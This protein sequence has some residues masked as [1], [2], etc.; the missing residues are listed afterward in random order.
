MARL[1]RSA[2]LLVLFGTL[3]L[4]A[5]AEPITAIISAIGSAIGA[6]GVGTLVSWAVVAYSVVSSIYGSVQ[7]KKQAR[8]AAERKFQ[9]DVANLQDRTTTI[10]ASDDSWPVVYGQP[11]P[12]GGSVKAVITSG[13]KAQYKHIVLVLA[14]HECEAIDDVL[15]DGESLQLNGYGSSQHPAYQLEYGLPRD[16]TY[17]FEVKAFDVFNSEGSQTDTIYAAVVNTSADGQFYSPQIVSIKNS[18]GADVALTLGNRLSVPSQIGNVGFVL[19]G[20]QSHLG[21]TGNVTIRVDGPGSA[22]HVSKHLSRGGVDFADPI[23]MGAQPNLWTANHKLTGFTY[24]VIT[25]NLLLERFQ[26]GMP[27]FTAR[28][29]GKRVYDPR[30]GQTA[31]SRNPALCLAD[32]LRSET[33]Y[34]AKLEQIEPNA[35]VAAANA[36]D[37]VVYGAGAWNDRET[38]GN[39]IRLYVCDGMFRSDQDRD[40]T[41][42]QLED[43]MAGYSLES[44]GVWRILAGAWSTP[45]LSLTDADLLGPTSVVQTCNPGTARYN[46]SRG[47]YVNQGRNG[48]AEDMS[49]Y[50]NAVFRA[51]DE[52]DKWLDIALSFTASHARCHQLARTL[53]E[54]S[55]GGLILQISPKMLAWHLQ[56]G[57]RITLSSALYG[58]ANK[59]F[60]VQDW[61]YVQNSPLSLQIIE[62]EPSF[63]DA[64]DEVQADPAPNTNLPSPFLVP[65]APFDVAVRS[66][67]EE[68]VVQGGTAV[69][70]VH[71]TWGLSN[72]PAVRMGGT[73]RV[74][75]RTVVPVGEWQT[76]DLPGGAVEAY[77]LGLAVRDEYQV[78]VRF[79]TAYV[80][81]NWVTVTHT[82]T[83][84]GEHP[85]DVAGLSL[86]ITPAGIVASW[87]Q[88]TG[89]ALLDW[90]T[91]S[92]RIGATWE[93]ANEVFSGKATSASLGWLQAGT[94]RVW[95][96]HSNTSNEWSVPVS[97]TID[98]LA[99]S[100]PVVSGAVW[101]NEVE[102]AWQDCRTTQPLSFYLVS[103]GPT[104]AESM[105]IARPTDRQ[106]T[107]TEE[108]GSY[109]YWVRAVDAGG[110]ASA[111]G[112]VQ[113][114]VLPG[115]DEALAELEQGLNEQVDQLKQ[116]DQ[117]TGVALA[118]EVQDRV[119]ALAAETQARITAINAEAAT[120]S[121]ALVSEA[122]SRTQQIT[123]VTNA[124]T[125]EATARAEADLVETT[126]RIA[127]VSQEATDRQAA[128]A[129]EATTRANAITAEANT[130][131]AALLA[132]TNNRTAAIT[133]EATTRQQADEALSS[134]LT[135]LNASLGATNAALQTEATARATADQAEATT[136]QQLATQLQAAD[137]TLTAAV[138]NEATARSTADAAEARSRESL[139]AALVGTKDVAA[140]LSYVDGPSLKLSFTG[141]NY[142]V[143]EALTLTHLGSGLIA[144]ERQ[145]RITSDAAEVSARETLQAQMTGGYTGSDL[146]QVVSGLIYQERTAR[147]TSDE[148]LAQQITLISAG[149]GEQFDPAKIWY[150]DSG[151]EAWTGNG[152][153]TAAAG[154][155]RPANH[156]TDPYAVSPVGVAANGSTYSQ[157]RLRIRKVGA[158]VWAGTIFWRAAA[159]ASFA[160][161]RSTAMTEPTYDGAG[162]GMVTVNP[163]WAVDVDQIRIDLSTAQTATDY[164]EVDWLAIGRPSPGA[165]NA[166]LS[167][168]IAARANADSAETTARESLA[169]QLRGSYAG[170][171]VAG[172]TSGLLA[173]ER[174]AR[175][176][177]DAA[178]VTARQQLAATVATNKTNSDAALLTEATTRAEADAAE[179]TARQ[180]LAATVA[181]NQATLNAALTAEQTARANADAAEVTARETL[182]TQM[183][184][185]YAGT[186][187]AAVTSG[188]IYS[189]R[190]A[191]ITADNAEIT[192]RAALAATVTNNKTASD[193]ALVNE[194]TLRVNGD[195]ANANAITALQ[196]TV[197]NN[198]TTGAAALQTEATA[199]ATADSAEALQRQGLSVAL[200]GVP[201]TSGSLDTVIG[202]SLDLNFVAKQFKVWEK[203]TGPTLTSGLIYEER[204]A[205][206]TADTAEV[207]A[208][209]ALE[210]VVNANKAQATAA[211][212]TEQTARASADAAEVTARETFQTQMRGTYAGTDIASVTSGLM[213]SERQARITADAAEVT[214]RQQLA[215][216]VA[217]NKTAVDAAMATEQTARANADTAEVT[218]RQ[219]L[220]SKILG[221]TDP[222][223]A[224]LANLTSGILF[225]ERQARTTADT[226]EVTARQQLAATV[227]SNHTTLNAAI[228]AE[229]T[230]R[231][232]ADTVNANAINAVS[233]TVAGHTASISTT[234]T[235]L[236]T[237]DGKVKSTWRLNVQADGHIAGMILESNGSTSSMVI[238]VDKFAIAQ[239]GTGGAVKYPFIVGSID[240][241]S[242]IGVNGNMFIDGSIKARSLDV[243]NLSATISKLNYIDA[244]QIAIHGNMAGN[245][246]GFIRSAGK[247]RDDNWGWIFAQHPDGSMFV[248]MNLNGCGIVMQHAANQFANFHMWGPGFDLSNGGLTI[249]QIDVIGALNIRGRSVTVPTARSEGGPTTIITH[250]VP[251]NNGQWVTTYITASTFIPAG[252]GGGAGGFL[253]IQ[254]DGAA[255]WIG[256]GLPG[257]TV[258]GTVVLDLSPGRHSVAAIGTFA[259]SNTSIFALS[260]QR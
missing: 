12:I 196:A 168:E 250:E 154:W 73:V 9:Q 210:A 27:T 4:A 132:E 10:V 166:A 147:A 182:Q 17:P 63:Y 20:G 88:P 93:L 243:E 99:P 193:A 224:T 229:Q 49:P 126:A 35:L 5:S 120:R 56:P 195:T 215:A 258:T 187:V 259:G 116:V 85:E 201:D 230:A 153:P 256:G 118:Q 216:T 50:V 184:G 183:R 222:T 197:T 58:F 11:A 102:L 136:R 218:A 15:I 115:I 149:V 190:Q 200:T 103:R 244:G 141:E 117:A 96:T 180:A 108:T 232:T 211:L 186:D 109:L 254:V 30:T 175:V 220:S 69:V 60:R 172:L 32:F 227:T 121:A 72:S 135:T 7:A 89:L 104:L 245:D 238:L 19:M 106:L 42:Q 155:L 87:Q 24:L 47:I 205:R 194:R 164:F 62:D 66:G 95:A 143:W 127:A 181:N 51:A 173:S 25:I 199:R 75:Y 236:A 131:A 39:D 206:I 34:L 192:A 43:A 98:I 46:G 110:N 71:V 213:Y 255:R 260:C 161:G 59:R 90:N 122:Q 54:Q 82:V 81:S 174:N 78:R 79:Q 40:T 209:Q 156:A 129:A 31:Y 61:T 16:I 144:E 150:F 119:A 203:P 191:R 91:T 167:A 77:I 83:G 171:D 165:S 212:T 242:S 225:E 92:L 33:G 6:A 157:V 246:W 188:L 170:S 133:A 228:T 8:A 68:I 65:D 235:A 67:V 208:R 128:V 23:L 123:Q 177:A 124:I 217:G 37:Q 202:Q 112:Y 38:F 28:V 94:V 48:V 198:A 45:V 237:L 140:D 204:Q 114:T 53:V 138:A 163:G 18:N 80:S 97:A 57:D 162:I 207:T 169:T 76:M 176:T 152:A 22:V 234:S 189:E 151:L 1:I 185:T 44:G 226:A 101:R 26:G 13:D 137:A 84:Q 252:A 249:N 241:V 55:R 41:R 134:Q 214:A 221:V 251:N 239:S 223:S 14:A 3:P 105:E 142:R 145:A 248:D 247:W 257:S 130:R 178:E 36:C 159:D 160:V 29:R 107:R 21:L 233:A 64:A 111:P 158:P 148:A 2:L 240:G 139:T 70:R 100:Q 179:V 253:Q 231:A 146:S 113:L 219:T 52:K 86:A 125:A 74:Q